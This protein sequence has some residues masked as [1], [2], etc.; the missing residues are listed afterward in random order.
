MCFKKF[1]KAF[2]ELRL[3]LRQIWTLV[4]FSQN[5][6]MNRGVF[7]NFDFWFIFRAMQA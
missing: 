5:L 4:T 1:C 2:V 6:V 7:E 3:C